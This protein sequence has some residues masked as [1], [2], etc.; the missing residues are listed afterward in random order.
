[1]KRKYCE[2]KTFKDEVGP[3]NIQACKLETQNENFELFHKNIRNFAV[4]IK[5][6]Q[7]RSQK[8]KKETISVTKVEIEIT[9]YILNSETEYLGRNI[10]FRCLI[11]L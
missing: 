10:L 8:F 4:L 2:C 1:M 11:D 3:L 6:V 9:L 7:N 5:S